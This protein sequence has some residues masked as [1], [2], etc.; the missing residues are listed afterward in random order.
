M[1]TELKTGL[2]IM[3]DFE[4]SVS[5]MCDVA[6]FWQFYTETNVELKRLG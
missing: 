3:A 6:V 4:F 2:I 1:S 5:Q